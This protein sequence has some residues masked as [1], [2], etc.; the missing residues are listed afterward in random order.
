MW[1]GF[2]CFGPQ[3]ICGPRSRHKGVSSLICF[4]QLFPTRDRERLS[5]CRNN[6]NSPP[7]PGVYLQ[8]PCLA[9]R[10]KQAPTPH[11]P[12]NSL[13]PHRMGVTRAQRGARV[14]PPGWSPLSRLWP[15]RSPKKQLFGRISPKN[16]PDDSRLFSKLSGSRRFPSVPPTLHSPLPPEG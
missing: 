8:S 1:Q 11:S 5:H 7:H 13:S 14:S 12:S 3:P 2:N 10:L 15:Q 6:P 9:L 16:F 4:L